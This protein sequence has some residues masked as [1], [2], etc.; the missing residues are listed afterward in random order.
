[1]DES[2]FL[3]DP[4]LLS[5]LAE[6]GTFD[7]EPNK[8]PLNS[9]IK[10]AA[11]ALAGDTSANQNDGTLELVPDVGSDDEDDDPSLRAD[12][13]ALMVGSGKSE[14]AGAPHSVASAAEPSSS[15]SVAKTAAAHKAA[16]ARKEA[17]AA[18]ATAL[19]ITQEAATA[20]K[21][22]SFALNKAGDKAGAA[23]KFRAFKAM[24]KE[25]AAAASASGGAS[26]A[27]SG[28]ASTSNDIPRMAP[29]AAA[30]TPDHALQAPVPPLGG[31]QDAVQTATESAMAAVTA[32]QSLLVDCEPAD[33][34]GDDPELLGACNVDRSDKRWYVKGWIF[35]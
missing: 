12:L 25:L 31:P 7:D 35:V 10:Q 26:S 17:A 1:M 6:L 28:S 20:L 19:G 30:S 11:A 8:M 23:A 21:L 9:P 18:R 29:V 14:A 15:S 33:G 22:E 16:A 13:A 32:A 34:D 24:E 27:P 2:S 5:E 3:D 4:E